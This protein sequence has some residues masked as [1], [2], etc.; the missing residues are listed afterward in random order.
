M[1]LC[2]RSY[3]SDD[4]GYEQEGDEQDGDGLSSPLSELEEKM[5]A[6]ELSASAASFTPPSPSRAEVEEKAAAA[7]LERVQRENEALRQT[8]EKP[9]APYN[10]TTS[11]RVYGC[12]SCAAH[13]NMEEDVVSKE[14]CG[15]TGRAYF[16]NQ[17]FNIKLGPVHECVFKTGKH[18]IADL[19]CAHCETSLDQRT[20]VGWKYLKTGVCSQKYKEG[21]FVVEEAMLVRLGWTGS[22]SNE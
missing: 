7:Q 11:G 5:R 19:L 21:K 13:I 8:L 20:V 14:F 22:G 2:S 4:E 18:V 17:V 15:S 3:P 16:V 12:G 1:P 6:R 9:A 10:I